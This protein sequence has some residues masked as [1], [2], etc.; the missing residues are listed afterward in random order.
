MVAS[1]IVVKL[2]F[3]SGLMRVI[4][5][6]MLGGTVFFFSSCILKNKIAIYIWKQIKKFVQV[7]I[8]R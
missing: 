8:A 6:V 7:K 3:D 5:S 4:I 2:L 1:L